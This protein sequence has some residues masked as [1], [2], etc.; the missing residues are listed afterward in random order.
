MDM[1]TITP[2]SNDIKKDVQELVSIVTEDNISESNI[3]KYYKMYYKYGSFGSSLK[4]DIAVADITGIRTVS[5]RFGDL[6]LSILSKYGL[7]GQRLVVECTE[8][9][10]RTRTKK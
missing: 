5:R 6:F 8:I 4:H 2:T 3:R 9:L 1:A 7:Q 10:T